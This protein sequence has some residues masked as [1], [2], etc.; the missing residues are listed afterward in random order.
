MLRGHNVSV[1]NAEYDLIKKLSI[2]CMVLPNVKFYMIMLWCGMGMG[3][4]YKFWS[5]GS[6]T[7]MKVLTV[8]IMFIALFIWATSHVAY[9]VMITIER[10]Y[11]ERLPR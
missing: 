11:K 4:V 6:D 9:W 7:D 1:K 2:D 10:K 3:I 8:A 5:V